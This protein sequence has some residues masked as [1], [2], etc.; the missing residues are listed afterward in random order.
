MT[1]TSRQNLARALIFKLHNKIITINIRQLL[2]STLMVFS[3]MS[4]AGI[5]AI[6]ITVSQGKIVVVSFE[7][8]HA[9][10]GH[11][12]AR[13]ALVHLHDEALL[14]AFVVGGFLVFVAVSEI[15]VQVGA[16]LRDGKEA[17]DFDWSNFRKFG[18][19]KFQILWVPFQIPICVNFPCSKGTGCVT[20]S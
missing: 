19:E 5:V 17:S 7:V 3:L 8:F 12:V 11:A 4:V 1:V 6:I 2:I 16:H 18:K 15:R 20:T 10:N 13:L 14:F 9:E